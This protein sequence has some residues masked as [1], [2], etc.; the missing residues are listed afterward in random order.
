MALRVGSN[1]V[2]AEVTRLTIPEIDVR[3]AAWRLAGESFPVW[4][5][6]KAFKNAAVE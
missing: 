2:A 5:E 4:S 1:I 6:V 3:N